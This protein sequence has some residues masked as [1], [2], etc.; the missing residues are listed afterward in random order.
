MATVFVFTLAF[1][2]VFDDGWLGVVDGDGDGRDGEDG[3]LGDAR[4]VNIVDKG[5]GDLGLCRSC[6]AFPPPRNWA[7]GGALIWMGNVP[8]SPP[9]ATC[10]SS[11]SSFSSCSPS[12]SS[13]SELLSS[14]CPAPETVTR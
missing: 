9:L 2:F 4:E 12:P 10:S 8:P 6:T 5:G 13:R 1:V 7:R 14:T 3:D 11:S